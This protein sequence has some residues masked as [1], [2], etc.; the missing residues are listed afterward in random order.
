M[1]FDPDVSILA[2]I[3]SNDKIIYEF[4]ISCLLELNNKNS[5]TL[6]YFSEILGDLDEDRVNYDKR[7]VKSKLV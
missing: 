1:E 5:D 4:V 6:P 2:D 3:V 7:L